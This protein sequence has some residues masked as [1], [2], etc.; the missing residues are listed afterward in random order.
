MRLKD[1]LRSCRCRI[2]LF[3]CLVLLSYRLAGQ[4]GDEAGHPLPDAPKAGAAETKSFF[5]RWAEFYRQD[6]RGTAAS[7]STTSSSTAS[8]S[9]ASSSTPARRG[10]PSP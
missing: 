1:N 4:Q 3:L 5:W 7:S 2:F 8:S 10:L 6:W 9:T